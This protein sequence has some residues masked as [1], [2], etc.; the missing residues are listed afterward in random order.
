MPPTM[1]ESSSTPPHERF[2]DRWTAL[3]SSK[4]RSSLLPKYWNLCRYLA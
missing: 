2:T 4:F 1:H 3:K